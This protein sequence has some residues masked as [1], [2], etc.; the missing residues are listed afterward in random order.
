MEKEKIKSTFWGPTCDSMDKLGENIIFPQIEIDT[1]LV[2]Y[3]MGAYTNASATK[4]NGI[5]SPVIIVKD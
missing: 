5:E 2:L 1:E 4:F 3:N